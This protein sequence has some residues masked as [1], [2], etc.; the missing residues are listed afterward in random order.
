MTIDQIISKLGKRG[1]ALVCAAVILL[2]VVILRPYISGSSAVA[3]EI[4]DE[5]HL[6]RLV[7]QIDSDDEM[8]AMQAVTDLGR[9]DVKTVS[10]KLTEALKDPR[11]NV[12]VAA[13]RALG[14]IE[15]WDAMPSLIDALDDDELNVRIAAHKSVVKLM[16]IDYGFQPNSHRAARRQYIAGL[17]KNYQREHKAF[18]NWQKRKAER[19]GG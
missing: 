11:P 10:G 15:V 19:Q 2:L 8:V 16:G 7:D 3:T 17:K 4:D 18:L 13:A 14:R 6:K 9:F 12:R 1:V 5:D